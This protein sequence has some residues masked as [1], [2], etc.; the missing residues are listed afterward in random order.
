MSNGFIY[1]IRLILIKTNIMN[2]P[3]LLQV[4]N[5]DKKLDVV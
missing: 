1:N 2:N 5:F 3:E 4:Y